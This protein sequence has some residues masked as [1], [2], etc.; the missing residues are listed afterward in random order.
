MYCTSFHWANN[1]VVDDGVY[2]SPAPPTLDPPDNCVYQPLNVAPVFV[3]VGNV[4][5]SPTYCAV[6]VPFE[7]PYVYV[8]AT[9]V[10]PPVNFQPSNAV[11]C[12]C[13]NDLYL[14]H[15]LY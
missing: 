14:F 11:V 5:A 2:D 10:P 13:C 4:I 3:G 8:G 6:N 12:I 9:N 7:V 1:V 15:H